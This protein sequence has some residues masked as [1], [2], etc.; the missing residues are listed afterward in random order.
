LGFWVQEFGQLM[1]W[2]VRYQERQV[3][4]LLAPAVFAAPGQVQ[5]GLLH[6]L[7]VVVLLWNCQ[8]Q[9]LAALHAA[10]AAAAPLAL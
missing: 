8:A 1:G 6:L 4:L 3:W 2:L 7:P 5:Q 9:V 10:A